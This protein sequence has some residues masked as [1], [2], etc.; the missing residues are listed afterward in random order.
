VSQHP[1]PMPTGSRVRAI[2]TDGRSR[3]AS[4][5]H[6]QRDD[7]PEGVGVPRERRGR[8]AD[9]RVDGEVD[10]GEAAGKDLYVIGIESSTGARLCGARDLVA[11]G[12]E[13]DS[14][15]A[16]RVR[17]RPGSDVAATREQE[18]HVRGWFGARLLG[19]A[20][21]ADWA[22]RHCAPESAWRGRRMRTDRGQQPND[23]RDEK[24]FHG[25]ESRP[26]ERAA[27]RRPSRPR[28]GLGVV[29]GTASRA[30][31]TAS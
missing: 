30:R 11:P 5:D 25:A 8:S 28:V 1:R 16:G 18:C 7:K 12:S 24:P 15:L 10:A 4:R 31:V 22:S 21:R 14:V 26:M 23:G 20:D 6:P 17:R 19:D 3:R 29:T 27:I 2:G 13:P 9:S